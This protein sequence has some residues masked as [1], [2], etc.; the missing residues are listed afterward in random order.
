MDI[1]TTQPHTLYENIYIK[2][3][4]YCE[5][6][7]CRTFYDLMQVYVADLFLIVPT[8]GMKDSTA[9]IKTKERQ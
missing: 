2:E 9:C 8:L 5:S 6:L 1:N 7:T 3:S 4:R